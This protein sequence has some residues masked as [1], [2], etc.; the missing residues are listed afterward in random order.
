MARSP[1]KIA[2]VDLETTGLDPKG[3]ILEV[4]FAVIEDLE[5][6]DQATVHSLLIH[7]DVAYALSSADQFVKDMHTANGLWDDLSDPDKDKFVIS[8]AED[9]IFREIQRVG[10][11]SFDRPV[12]LLGNSIALD[13]AFIQYWMHLLDAR[14]HYRMLDLTSV[15][16]LIQGLGGPNTKVAAESNHRAA[17]DVRLTI[18]QLANQAEIL[19]TGLRHV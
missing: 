10:E 3:N 11:G 4:A 8:D 5:Q 1:R 14:L 18:R 19:R 13:R 16:L 12:Y 17:D 2:F 7:T 6:A 15:N 9:I